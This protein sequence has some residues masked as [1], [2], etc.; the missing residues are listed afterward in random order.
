MLTINYNLEG[1]RLDQSA[2]LQSGFQHATNRSKP[3]NG[4]AF[5]RHF[6]EPLYNF[7]L[8]SY[9]LPLEDRVVTDIVVSIHQNREERDWFQNKKAL[10][11]DAER[12]AFLA[13]CDRRLNRKARRRRQCRVPRKAPRS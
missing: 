1:E 8:L 7:L 13:R 12:E 11:A 2:R 9:L 10:E 4:L 6:G 5:S 3:F